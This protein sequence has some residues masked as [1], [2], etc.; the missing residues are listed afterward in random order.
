[1]NRI[2][3][4]VS[5]VLIVVGLA[6]VFFYLA[7]KNAANGT[8]ILENPSYYIRQNYW[9]VFLAGSA[10][11]L[12]ALLGSFFT[13]HK[14]SQPEEEVLLNAGFVAKEQI[15]D[16]VGGSSLDNAAEMEAGLNKD[17]TEIALEG[18]KTQIMPE[19]EK[20]KV[21]WGDEKT[22]IVSEEERT[23]LL[24]EEGGTEILQEDEETQVMPEEERTEIAA[25][26]TWTRTGGKPI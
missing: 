10:V 21:R 4:A 25:D 2:L 6:F 13:W 7:A 26:R 3:K 22:Q 14:K 18:E 5:A 20:T 16:W 12:F 8:D 17:G 1:M 24:S 15:R 19:E 9:Y 23:E 11:I